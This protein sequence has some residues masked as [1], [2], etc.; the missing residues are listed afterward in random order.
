MTSTNVPKAISRELAFA[1]ALAYFLAYVLALAFAV[2]TPVP[3]L[4][5]C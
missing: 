1:F 4:M 2:L 5:I 3:V